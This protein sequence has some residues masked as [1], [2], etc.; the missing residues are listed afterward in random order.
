MERWILLSSNTN[1]AC[2]ISRHQATSPR[3]RLEVRIQ[4]LHL[5]LDQTSHV[6]LCDCSQFGDRQRY[7]KL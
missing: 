3:F 7:P 1:I 4:N 2:L 6:R 5:A